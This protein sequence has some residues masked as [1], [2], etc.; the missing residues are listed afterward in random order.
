MPFQ[1]FANRGNPMQANEQILQ[2]L[3]EIEKRFTNLEA[4]VKARDAAQK[5]RDDL[6]KVQNDSQE[7]RLTR[8]ESELKETRTEMVELRKEGADQRVSQARVEAK[9]DALI[10]HLKEQKTDKS[11]NWKITGIVASILI[12][13][14][15][16]LKSFFFG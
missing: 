5:I 1:T 2:K 4:D 8:I 13:V 12:G 3:E 6:Q 11:E 14:A 7:H 10:D 15:A 16:F 9:L